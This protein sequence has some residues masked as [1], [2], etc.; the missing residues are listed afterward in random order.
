MRHGGNV[1][2]GGRP[3]FWLDFSASLR[4]EGPPEWVQKVMRRALNDIRYYP[5]RSMRAAREGLAAYAGVTED[6]VLPAAGGIA[7][8]G[9]AL[10][11]RRGPVFVDTPTFGEYTRLAAANGRR[12]AGARIAGGTRVV[13]NPN[14]PTGS[15]LPRGEVLSLSREME[16]AGGELLSDEAFADYCPEVSVRRFASP[17]LTVAGSLTKILCIPGARLGYVCGTEEAI[18]RMAEKSSPWP[19]NALA[20]AVAAALPG[21]LEEI[22]SD[23]ALNRERRGAFREELT[24]LGVRVLPSQAN[25][26]LCDFGRD[27]TRAAEALKGQGILVRTCRSFGLGDSWLRLAVRTE[28]ENRM[29]TERLKPWVKS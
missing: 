23:A 7:A 19:L 26:L 17:A 4:P 14:N 24:E 8:I 1:W 21:H 12:A 29:L 5:D 22:R 13:C 25:F 9:L 2:E 6:R 27:M 10:S 28:E 16:K 20:A 18:E 15:A 3:E 11:M